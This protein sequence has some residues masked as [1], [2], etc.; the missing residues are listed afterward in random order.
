MPTDDGLWFTRVPHPAA[1]VPLGHNLAA[2]LATAF[3]E[4]TP[5][6]DAITTAVLHYRTALADALLERLDNRP[7][8]CGRTLAE[9]LPTPEQ[10]RPPAETPVTTLTPDPDAA[11]PT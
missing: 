5:Q 2:Y 9:H 3:P 1:T 10:N 7:C 6:D 11:T 8:P 4:A